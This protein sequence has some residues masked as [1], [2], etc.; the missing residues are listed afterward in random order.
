MLSRYHGQLWV[1]LAGK[2]TFKLSSVQSSSLYLGSQNILN[3][4]GEYKVVYDNKDNMQFCVTQLLCL[5]ESILPSTMHNELLMRLISRLLLEPEHL[6]CP[7]MRH[8]QTMTAA[9]QCQMHS[10]KHSAVALSSMRNNLPVSDLA[11]GSSWFAADNRTTLKAPQTA[12]FEFASSG[13]YPL[14]LNYVTQQ[15]GK[16][17]VSHCLPACS[18]HCPQVIGT[19]LV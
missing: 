4:S 14:G 11:K 5:G 17:G 8:C 15:A 3:C 7:C 1:P 18:V 13:Y 12:T 6:I 16:P 19:C 9:T 2:Y 10:S